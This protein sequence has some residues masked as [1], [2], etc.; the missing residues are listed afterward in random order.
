VRSYAAKV[1][2][3]NLLLAA[4]I[5]RAGL[6]HAGLAKQLNVAGGPIGLRY[7]HASVAR[8][9]RDHATPRD[10]VPE[11]ICTIVGR[12][13]GIDVSPAD[14]GMMRGQTAERL[15]SLARTVD[16]AAALWR[17]EIRGR[18]P[19]TLIV[20][21]QAAA[22]VWEWENPPDDE[23]VTRPG[24]RRV[25]IADVLRV[26]HARNHYQEMYRRVG[27]V[28][29]RP[30]I[31]AMLNERTAPLLH[32]AYDNQLGRRLYR[33]V[34][35]LAALAGVCA[36]DAD[37]QPLAQRHLFT[38]LRLAKASGDRQFGAYVV[39][40]LANQALFLDEHRLVVQYTESALRAAGP[41]LAPALVTDLHSLAG[42][43]YA[44]MGDAH[45]CHPHLRESERVAGRITH[46]EGPEEISYVLPGL[47]ETQSAEALRRLGDLGAA[48]TYAEES[49][50]TAP[51]THLR[52]QVH[53][54]AGLALI[55]TARG[56]LDQGVH[57]AGQMLDRAIGIESG[58]IRDR[59][60][61]VVQA[62]RPRAREPV[63]TAF[64][65]RAGEH[66]HTKDI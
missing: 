6:S 4:L 11:L 32:A 26:Q 52:G 58:R 24:H 14:I 31:A 57:V 50:R 15:P 7:D 43:A 39:A 5:E 42:K 25:D 17:G 12:R 23:D 19:S 20:G 64:L 28:P 3:P 27:G 21:A 62:L 30:R 59:V 29:V 53:R 2:E 36:Y 35:G 1:T 45:A 9:I 8:W 13:L 33:A 46:A 38:A 61:Q 63:V 10:P 66:I 40:L 55:L 47:V 56:D 18:V 37:Q 49:V 54:Y 41:R 65:E 44:R 51:A 16:R 48:Q 22:P 34:G 60:D